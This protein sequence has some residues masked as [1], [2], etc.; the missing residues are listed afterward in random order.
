[1]AT[2]YFILPK[3]PEMLAERSRPKAGS[4]KWDLVILSLFGILTLA[5]Y[6]VAGLDF[7]NGWSQDFSQG[8]QIAGLVVAVIGNDLIL[9]WAMVTNAFFVATVRIQKERKHAVVSSGPYQ[10]VRHPGY[11]GTIL[12]HLATPFLLNSSWALIPVGLSVILLLVRTALEDRTLQSELAGYKDYAARV[13]Y[14][15]LPG[16]W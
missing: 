3:N 11:A 12:F 8:L 5:E 14:R 7:R 15:L 9:V 16:V 6:M 4:K 2:A 1:M 13:R 10:F